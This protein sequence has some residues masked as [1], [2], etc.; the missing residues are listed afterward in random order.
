MIA[1]LSILQALIHVGY[2]KPYAYMVEIPAHVYIRTTYV[3]T[4]SRHLV[5]HGIYNV[6][7]GIGEENALS[8][9]IEVGNER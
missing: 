5:L 4:R 8:V 3:Q 6:T 7:A 1:H 2:D 9:G